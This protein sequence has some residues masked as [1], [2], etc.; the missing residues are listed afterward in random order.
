MGSGTARSLQAFESALRAL[1][2][3]RGDPG[4]I[5]EEALAEDPDFATGTT[6][7][8]SPFL[9]APRYLGSTSASPDKKQPAVGVSP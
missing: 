9:R 8:L 4:A 2:I 6:F 1:N 7:L 5:I 3:Y